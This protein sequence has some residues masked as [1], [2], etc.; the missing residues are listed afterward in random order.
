MAI[1]RLGKR[2]KDD[3]EKQGSYDPNKEIAKVRGT[4]RG[5]HNGFQ[6][7]NTIQMK[8]E[9]LKKIASQLMMSTKNDKERGDIG[10]VEKEIDS[11]NNLED[12]QEKMRV[13]EKNIFKF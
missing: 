5:F 12:I 2:D 8:K 4:L 3:N 11:S 7:E 9:F 13:F 10:N 1:E 6:S